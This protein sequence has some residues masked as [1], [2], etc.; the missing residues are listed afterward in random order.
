M[1]LLR[2]TSL[3]TKRDVRLLNNLTADCLMWR[4]LHIKR[5]VRTQ[6][7]TAQIQQAVEVSP[8]VR[9][10]SVL[11]CQGSSKNPEQLHALR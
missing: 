10:R 1:R 2:L 6:M 5:T 11:C 7:Q 3:S 9:A 8:M 4:L